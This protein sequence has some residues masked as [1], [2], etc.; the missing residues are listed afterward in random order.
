MRSPLLVAALLVALPAGAVTIDWLTVG[1]PGN[2]P[3]TAT[4]CPSDTPDCGLVAEAYRISKYEGKSAQYAGFLNALAGADPT[5]HEN[6]PV[7]FVSFY[8]A[9]RFANCL[10]KVAAVRIRPTEPIAP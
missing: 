8:D 4:N 9:L 1:D 6:N 2:P 7:V 10:H 5:G 3:D